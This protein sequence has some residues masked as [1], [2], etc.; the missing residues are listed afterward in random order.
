MV[1]VEI[2]KP[3]YTEVYA[4]ELGKKPPPADQKIFQ[5]NF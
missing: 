5:M 4:I 1:I 3:E 2:L